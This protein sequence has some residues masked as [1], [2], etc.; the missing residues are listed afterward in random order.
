MAQTHNPPFPAMIHKK[1]TN[2]EI[3][4]VQKIVR[5]ILYYGRAVDMT[6]LMVLSTIASKQT[7]GM[8]CTLNKAYQVLDYLATHHDATV[9][10]CASNMVMNIHLDASYLSKPNACSR[11]CGHF[12]HGII[13]N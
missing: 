7:K 10:I 5:S 9:Q 6:V 11:A 3:K 13:T 2:S 12:F 4:Q 8:E 1:A